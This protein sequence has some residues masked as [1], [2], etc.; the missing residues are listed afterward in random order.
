M[1]LSFADKETEKIFNQEYSKR[2]SRGLARKAL[3]KLI[4]IDHASALGELRNPPSHHLEIL[5]GNLA[6]K[7]S[8]R[9]NDRWRIVFQPIDG[10]ANYCDVEVTN[11]H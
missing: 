2:F 11:Y 6:G 4:L 10:G 5:Q 7:W 1:I 9:I 8:T 3:Q